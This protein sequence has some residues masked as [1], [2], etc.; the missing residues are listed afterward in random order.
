MPLLYLAWVKPDVR[1][2]PDILCYPHKERGQDYGQQERHRTPRSV[3]LKMHFGPEKNNDYIYEQKIPNVVKEMVREEIQ[4]GKHRK[5][6][7]MKVSRKMFVRKLEKNKGAR[8]I[9]PDCR[10]K[11]TGE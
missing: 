9:A 8:N 5:Y 6:P 1:K 2:G 3:H 7:Y 10:I 11:K 4:I